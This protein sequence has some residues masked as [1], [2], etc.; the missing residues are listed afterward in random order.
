MNKKLTAVQC[1]RWSYDCDM[2]FVFYGPQCSVTGGHM[3]AT[4]TL[5]FM[6]SMTQHFRF[7]LYCYMNVL[8]RLLFNICCQNELV[9]VSVKWTCIYNIFIINII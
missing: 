1:H 3:I 6:V 2:Y 4:C 9:S 5:F 7:V 8:L